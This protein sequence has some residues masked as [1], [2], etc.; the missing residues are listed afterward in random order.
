MRTE[1]PMATRAVKRFNNL[2]A[3]VG[4]WSYENFKFN[5]S[6]V[7]EHTVLGPV[8]PLLGIIEEIGELFD[9]ITVCEL[10]D[11]IADVMIFLADFHY[12]KGFNS[13]TLIL[14]NRVADRIE[15]ESGISLERQTEKMLMS[16][17]GR[18]AHIE[19]KR[20]QAIRG[21]GETLQYISEMSVIITDIL[22]LLAR[23]Y[24]IHTDDI[25]TLDEMLT[26]T[27]KV[28]DSVKQR[29]WT[30]SPAPVPAL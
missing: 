15:V 4:I 16:N 23:I 21:Y 20:H 17:V 6:K 29:K 12:R 26:L 5:V 30:T 14:W 24:C 3:E 7:D 19:L 13:A 11:A 18:L 8:A 10:K 1:H 28:W 9:S 22:V 2:I 25:L 27:E